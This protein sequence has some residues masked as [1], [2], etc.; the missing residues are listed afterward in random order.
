MESDAERWNARYSASGAP[1]QLQPPEVVTAH[2]GDLAHGAAVLDAAS[3]WGDA[4]LF[5]AQHGAA[6]TFADVSSVALLTVVDRAQA[7]GVHATTIAV[8]LSTSTVPIGPWDAIVCI[9]YLDRGL[10]PRLGDALAPGG[11]LVCSIA[12][13]TNLE[14]HERPSARF[15]LEPGEL[16]TLV[17][18]LDVIHASEAWRANGVHEAWL[19]A[20]STRE[21][22]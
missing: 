16:Q 5:L 17:P 20:T 8:D 19:V 14:R 4:G 18:D 10:L 13:T 11:R 9:H 3:G 7:L 2:L 1:E 12:T 22:D 21:P 6:V 15:L